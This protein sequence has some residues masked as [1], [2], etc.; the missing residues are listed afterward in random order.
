MS[1]I[2]RVDRSKQE[3]T[4]GS[5]VPEDRSHTRNRGDGQQ[6]G[7]VVLTEEER[8]AGAAQGAGASQPTEA[9]L[10]TN[11]GDIFIKLFN[12]ECPRTIENFTTHARAGYY[13]HV[14]FHRVIKGFMIQTGTVQ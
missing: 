9:V 4:D 13:D 12:Q 6:V 11:Y 1:D 2:P 8:G 10:H 5:P 3:L 7:Y 14:L